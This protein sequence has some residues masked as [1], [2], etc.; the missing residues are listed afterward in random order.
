MGE[1]MR[2]FFIVNA[3]RSGSTLLV[4]MLGVHRRIVTLIE[5]RWFVYVSACLRRLERTL[6][7]G[8]RAEA[9]CEL[10]RTAERLDQLSTPGEKL[11]EIVDEY[12]GSP[13]SILSALM[14]EFAARTK[15]SADLWGEKSCLH[16]FHLKAID[17]VFPDARYI[18]LVRDPRANVHSLAQP[19]F[20]DFSNDWAVATHIYVRFNQAIEDELARIAPERHMRIHYEDLV[21]RPR[22][23]LQRCCEF[24]RVEF[25]PMVLQ[26]EMLPR[27]LD[28]LG[29]VGAANAVSPAFVDEWQQALSPTQVRC[30]ERVTA[31]LKLA[32][33]YPRS[34]AKTAPVSY[35]V[36]LGV[37]LAKHGCLRLAETAV[38]TIRGRPWVWSR[39]GVMRDSALRSVASRLGILRALGVSRP[40]SASGERS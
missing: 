24:I 29:S 8:N 3:P 4:A 6:P 22:E 9:M 38:Q 16:G 37:V 30:I 14:A 10:L 32:S 2:P 17:R 5:S 40:S 31:H 39:L 7:P 1:R 19:S 35:A 34:R 20:G 25:D 27:K 28:G 21:T 36:G 18:H 33:G 15:P 23:E 12:Q 13:D 26:H 11:R